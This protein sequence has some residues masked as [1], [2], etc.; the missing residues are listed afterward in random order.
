MFQQ[1]ISWCLSDRSWKEQTSYDMGIQMAKNDLELAHKNPCEYKEVYRLRGRS[2]CVHDRHFV[3]GYND[4][5][6]SVGMLKIVF[7]YIYA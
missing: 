2:S 1:V 4:F 6:E 5:A 7:V 3:Y